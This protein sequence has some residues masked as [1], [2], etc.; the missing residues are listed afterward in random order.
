MSTFDERE[1]AF[2]SKFAH[3][4]AMTFKA[5]AR[6]AKKLA[7]WAGEKLGKGE[8]EIDA[9]V[10]EVIR[11]DMEEAGAEDVI[12]KVS[13][14]FGEAVSIEDIRAQHQAFLSE[15]KAELSKS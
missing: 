4:A 9:Y 13:A 1:A 5:E 8:T 11:A 7:I 3:D 10:L 14:D 6:A 2:E 15:A 12:R